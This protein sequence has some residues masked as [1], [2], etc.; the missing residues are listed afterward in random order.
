MFIYIHLKQKSLC[1]WGCHLSP[2]QVRNWD[3][4][5]TLDGLK[6]GET[7][8]KHKEEEQGY[9]GADFTVCTMNVF[10]EDFTSFWREVPETGWEHTG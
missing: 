2:K 5:G 8:K 4:R 6:W 9:Q 1:R 7:A 3:V 10:A